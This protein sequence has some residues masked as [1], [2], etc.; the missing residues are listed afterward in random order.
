MRPPAVPPEEPWS[1]AALHTAAAAPADD[2]IHLGVFFQSQSVFDPHGRLRLQQRAESTVNVVICDLTSY[3][4]LILL[5]LDGQS[6]N[7]LL[8]NLSRFF[9]Y[10]YIT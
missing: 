9:R 7:T 10:L 3:S 5:V 6:T 2:I 4:F 8:L 1:P